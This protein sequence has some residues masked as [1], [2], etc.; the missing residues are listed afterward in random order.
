M[1]ET[2]DEN[3]KLVGI[4]QGAAPCYYGE[5]KPLEIGGAYNNS[6][7]FSS[8]KENLEISVRFC[9]HCHLLYWDKE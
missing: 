6:I 8:L 3:G 7:V 5:H 1:I 9:K 2:R 4:S